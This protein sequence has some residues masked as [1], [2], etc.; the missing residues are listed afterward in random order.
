VSFDEDVPMAAM[1][2]RNNKKFDRFLRAAIWCGAA[3]ALLLP[4][5]A[6]EFTREVSWGPED[7]IVM[8]AMLVAAAGACELA[9]WMSPDWNYRIAFGLAIGAAFLMVWSNL[10][11]GIIGHEGNPAN[12]MYFGVLGLLIVGS[13]LVRA[14]ADGMSFVLTLVALAF[15]S[16]SG[17]AWVFGMG[18]VPWTPIVIFTALW[19]ASAAMFRRA[20]RAAA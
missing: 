14:R 10:A 18:D 3:F 19:S 4:A 16:A 9:L 17:L 6:M 20:A 11:V 1:I 13:A 12:L 7:F 8:G 5:I 15:A 2:F